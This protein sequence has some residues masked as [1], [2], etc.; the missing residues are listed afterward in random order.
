[1]GQCELT[2]GSFHIFLQLILHRDPWMQHAPAKLVA[3]E[4]FNARQDY[5]IAHC[6]YQ[7]KAEATEYEV[8]L[9]SKHITMICLLFSLQYFFQ[10]V[11]QE[12]QHCG[13]LKTLAHRWVGSLSNGVFRFHPPLKDEDKEAHCKLVAMLKENSAFMFKVSYSLR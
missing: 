5:M 1:M 4:A 11:Q 12:V 6:D 7:G 10:I 8:D 2:E 9:V 3:V 13:E